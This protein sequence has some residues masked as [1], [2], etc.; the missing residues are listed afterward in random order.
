MSRNT[1]VLSRVILRVLSYTETT[2]VIKSV[3]SPVIANQLSYPLTKSVIANQ[4]RSQLRGQSRSKFWLSRKFCYVDV[5][6][7][8]DT[9]KAACQ[10]D[11]FI[12]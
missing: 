11:F 12:F 10:R 3:R 4:L 2:K 8:L 9:C 7:V 6:F 5:L 1:L